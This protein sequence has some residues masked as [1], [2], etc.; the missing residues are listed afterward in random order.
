MSRFNSN[1]VSASSDPA[2]HV[3][4]KFSGWW[5]ANSKGDPKPYVA[6]HDPA[7]PYGQA[8]IRAEALELLAPKAKDAVTVLDWLGQGPE[9]CGL[10]AAKGE[11]PTAPSNGTRKSRF[12]Q[13]A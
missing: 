1:A 4:G 8:C 7:L 10:K 9:E 11:T 5:K 6:I 3:V 13:S 2:V 12:T